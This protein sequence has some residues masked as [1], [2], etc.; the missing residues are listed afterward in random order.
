MGGQLLVLVVA[1]DREMSRSDPL[2]LDRTELLI[3]KF[4]QPT[5]AALLLRPELMVLK[6]KSVACS[7]LARLLDV[8]NQ[9]KCC[10][11]TH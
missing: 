4:H 8:D 3:I 7:F 6:T 9:L 1:M 11:L 2:R 10:A 5:P